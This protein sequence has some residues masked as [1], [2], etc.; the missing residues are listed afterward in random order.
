MKFNIQAIGY[1]LALLLAFGPGNDLQAQRYF[2]R[3][4][5]ESDGLLS[6]MVFD[7]AQ[8]T[9]GEMWFATRTGIS[10][11][12]GNQFVNY[13]QSDGLPTDTYAFLSIDPKGGLWALPRNGDLCVVHFTGTRWEVKFCEPERKKRPYFTAFDVFYMDTSLVVV[14]GTN[15]SGL[16]I[17]KDGL[18]KNYRTNEGV[19]ND[20]INGIAGTSDAIYIATGKGLS[21]IRDELLAPIDA[22]RSPYL[23]LPILAILEAP[24]FRNRSDT[25]LWML[26]ESW[27]GYLSS[28]SFHLVTSGFELPT[29]DV[30]NSCFLTV[31]DQGEIC[32][33]NPIYVYCYSERTGA[34]DRLD[35]SSGL[36]SDGGTSV[37][38]DREGNLWITGYRGITKI[39]SRRFQQ[40]SVRDGLFNIEV[41]SGLEISPG[42]YVFGHHGAVSFYDGKQFTPFIL[43]SNSGKGEFETRVQDIDVDRSGNLWLAVSANGVACIKKQRQLTWYGE[44]EGLQGAANTVLVASNGS[45]Y[46]GTNQGLFLFSNGSFVKQPFKSDLINNGIRKIFQGP[47]NTLYMATFGRGIAVLSGNKVT[48]ID[49]PGNP[50]ANNVYSIFFDNKG[51]GFA[52]TLSGLYAINDTLLSKIDSG[53][54]VIDRPVYLILQDQHGCL[55]FGTDN[56]ASRWNGLIM[57]HFTIREGFSGLEVNRDAGFEDHDGHIWFG[58][59]NGIT[60]FN[61]EYDYD[62]TTIPPPGVKIKFIEV[63]NDTLN[64]HENQVLPSDKNNL[65]FHFSVTSYI[66]EQQ[67]LYQCKL[68]GL[69]NEWSREI[70]TYYNEY[71]YNNLAPGTYRF[72]IKA[73][74]VLGIWSDPVCSATIRIKQPFWFQWW[75]ILLAALF[76]VSLFV[77]LTR[78][79]LIKRYNLRLTKMVAIRTRDLRRSEK[80]L[81]ESNKAKD[82]FFS[83]IAHDLKSPFNAILGMLELLTTEY[84]EFSDDERQK[85]LMNLR[86]ASTR[87]INLLENLLTWAQ[88]QKGLLP[89]EP[90][91]FDIMDLVRENVA[92]FEPSA[93]SKRITLDI[94]VSE[95]CV[96]YADRNMINTVVRN[97]ISNAIKFTYPDGSVTVRIDRGKSRTVTISLTDT[98]CGIREKTLKN[99]F[100]L[101]QRTTTKGTGNETGTGL[102]LILSKDFITKNGGKI[103]VE[104]KP[105]EGSTFFF[106]LLINPPE[107]SK[108]K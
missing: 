102:G 83:I 104:S 21:V 44:A 16:F 65:R 108:R 80:D 98:G 100:V 66:D 87:T 24:D 22:D 6:S 64:P 15:N 37:L 54:L 23:R 59:N 4:Y 25:L 8:D 72:C 71:A 47:A 28:D 41:A 35:R 61:P 62:L 88:A 11:Y 2:T 74:N 91:K 34:L 94:P 60:K 82:N 69:D 76:V 9:A 14:T 39:P 73:R 43:K 81:Q 46:A 70:S 107:P 3:T 84:S 93:K 29:K 106:T 49:S 40:F 79:V 90:E 103:W 1:L 51:N 56:G 31:C 12:T 86:S 38:N 89:F 33:G 101:D 5:T 75:F 85:I 45:V 20:R 50:L 17:C 30:G 57:D 10:R 52:G 48:N 68:E 36:I 13:K 26:G 42:R 53:G 63:E 95:H 7:V 55:W 99:L 92:L 77:I 32:F 19:G 58:T 27:L 105:E 67:I 97:L 96:V 78:F 18:W